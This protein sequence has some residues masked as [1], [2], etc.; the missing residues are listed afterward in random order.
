MKVGDVFT[1]KIRVRD[2]T[3]VYGL[4]TYVYFDSVIVEPVKVGD[5]IEPE[6][7][8]FLSQDGQAPSIVARMQE[9]ASNII[10]LGCSRMGPV[11][12]VSGQGAFCLIRFT[13]KSAGRTFINLLKDKTKLKDSIGKDL[14]YN[15]VNVEFDVTTEVIATIELVVE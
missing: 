1:L 8:G 6:D 14:P 4:S 12:G 10:V 9:D 3:D 7:G 11:Q 15:L 5:V 13:A 2:A